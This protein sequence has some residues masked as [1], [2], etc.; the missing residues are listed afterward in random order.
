MSNRNIFI[1]GAAGCGKSFLTQKAIENHNADDLLVTATTGMASLNLP[2][3]QTLHRTLGLGTHKKASK[4][5]G[6][7]WFRDYTLPHLRRAKILIVDEVSMLRSDTLELANEVMKGARDS[8]RP[9]GGIRV[10]LVGD[11]LQLPPVVKKHERGS[12]K[13][14]SEFCFNSPVWESLNLEIRNLTK[15]KRQTDKD[16][17]V[18][19]NKVRLGVVDSEVEELIYGTENA[20]FSGGVTPVRLLSTRAEVERV[21]QDELLKLNPLPETYYASIK[22]QTLHFKDCPAPEKLT[23]KKGC[24]VMFVRNDKDCR[25]VNGSMGEYLGNFMVKLYSGG[26]VVQLE[27]AT[28]EHKK[29]GSYFSQYPIRLAYAITIHKSQG[30]TIDYL[31]VDLGRCFAP[32]MAYVALSRGR[33]LGGLR[34][35]N[36]SRK[37]VKVN[38]H[39]LEFYRGIA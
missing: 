5:F 19:L 13:R 7:T 1:T 9:F 23:V 22:G 8:D 18:V 14:G 4:V 17:M 3:G 25:F 34:V 16:F 36:F 27:R 21:N 24:Q 12:F 37:S 29:S 11:F 15:I 20:V 28:W 6:A 35:K 39:C 38:Q 30:Q 26:E 10:I 33:T 31:E 2:G 32:G